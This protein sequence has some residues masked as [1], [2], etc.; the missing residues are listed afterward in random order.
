MWAGSLMDIL[1]IRLRQVWHI[2]WEQ[3]SLAD[4]ETGT[5]SEPHVRHEIIFSGI[6]RGLVKSVPKTEDVR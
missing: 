3:G 1:K 4:F 6:A 2:R 5:S